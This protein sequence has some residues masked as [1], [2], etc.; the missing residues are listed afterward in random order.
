MT[1]QKQW[2]DCIIYGDV[3]YTSYRGSIDF[4]IE[5]ILKT[6]FFLL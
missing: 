6:F 1:M 3:T 2:N 4:A 5:R